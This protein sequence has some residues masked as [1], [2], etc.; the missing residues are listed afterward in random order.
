VPY[1]FLQG[2]LPL[3]YQYAGIAQQQQQQQQA[4]QQQQ[5]AQQEL[6]QLQQQHSR[7]QVLSK[8]LGALLAAMA[9]HPEAVRGRAEYGAAEREQMEREDRAFGLNWNAAVGK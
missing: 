8:A 6:R 2:H 1:Q 5:Q 3:G 4:Q 7:L 9:Q